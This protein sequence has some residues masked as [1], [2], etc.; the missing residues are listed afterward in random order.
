VRV[1][2]GVPAGEWERASAALRERGRDAGLREVDVIVREVG[3]DAV[4]IEIRGRCSSGE[5][6]ARAE[7]ELR[8]AAAALTGA[9]HA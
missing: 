4:T 5:Q 6:A 7:A 1:R 3:A 2:A 9:E 8:A